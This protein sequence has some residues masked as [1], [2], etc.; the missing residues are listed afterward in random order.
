MRSQRG[1]RASTVWVLVIGF[2][3]YVGGAVTIGVASTE[4]PVIIGG[5]AAVAGAL[6][7]AFGS[8]EVARAKGYRRNWAAVGLLGLFGIIGLVALLLLP[9]RETKPILAPPAWAASTANADHLTLDRCPAC[10]RLVP[11]GQ[12][13]PECEAR[14]QQPRSHAWDMRVVAAVVVARSRSE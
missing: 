13:C 3:L 6:L 7:F 4:I 12:P 1:F 11:R 9:D 8:V 5:L 10:G 14:A 2:L